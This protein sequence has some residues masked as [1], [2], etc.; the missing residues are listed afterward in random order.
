MSKEIKPNRS[1]IIRVIISNYDNKGIK[2]VKVRYN[3]QAQLDTFIIESQIEEGAFILKNIKW[4]AKEKYRYEMLIKELNNTSVEIIKKDKF[5]NNEIVRGYRL[6]FKIS[7][8]NKDIVVVEI[9]DLLSLK[10]VQQ[11]ER[12]NVRRITSQT[13]RKLLNIETQISYSKIAS[14]F[15]EDIDS[16]KIYKIKRYLNYRSNMLLF[17]SLINDFLCE[18]LYDEKGNKINELW[19]ITNKV[20]KDIIDERVNKIAKNLDNT[21]SIEL[22]NYNNR[23]KKSI[24]KKKNSITD[25]KN[26]IVSC[27]RKIEKLDE[28]K[29]RKKISQFKRDIANCN[30]KIKEYEESIVLKEKEKLFNLGFEKIKDDVYK[31]LE[32]YTELRHKLSHYNYIYFENLFENREEDLKLA[33]LLNLNIFNYLTLSKKLR[34]ENKTNYL[35]EDTKF[36]I[37]GVSGSAKKYYSLYN[38]LCEQKNGFNNFINSFFVKDGVENSEFK[39]KVEAKLKEDIEYLESFEIKNNLNKRIPKKNKELELLKSQYNELGTVYFWD[40]HSS[41]NYKELYNKR[42]GTIENYNQILKGNRNKTTLRNYGRELF[43]KK[44]E[45]EKITKRNSIVRLKYKLQI[46]YAFIMKEFKGDISRFKSDFDISKIEQ[47]K[48]YQSRGEEY[49]NYCD[50]NNFKIKDFQKMIGEIESSSEITWLSNKVENNLF[51]FYVLTYIL[52]PIEFKGDF[53]G[54][55]KKHY[56]DI[57][58]V[59]Y[60]DENL[61]ELT[62]EELDKIKNDSF[63]NKIRLFEKNSKKYNIFS[64]SILIQERVKDYFK[65]LDIPAEHYEYTGSSGETKNIF[66]K[67]IVIPIFKYYEIVVKLYNDIEIAMLLYLS[68]IKNISIEKVINR[69]IEKQSNLK[70]EHKEFYTLTEL[71]GFFKLVNEKAEEFDSNIPIPKNYLNSK[72]IS[73]RNNIFHYNYEGFIGQLLDINS[74]G[75]S[76]FSVNIEIRKLLKFIDPYLKKL[77]ILHLDYNFINDYYMKK[78]Q[79]MFGQLK[80]VD[81]TITNNEEKERVIK[82]KRLLEICKLKLEKDNIEVINKIYEKSVL[83]KEIGETLKIETFNELNSLKENRVNLNKIKYIEDLCKKQKKNEQKIN[84]NKVKEEIIKCSSDVLGLYKQQIITLLKNKIIRKLKYKEEK[85]L[86]IITYEVET[87]AK[88]IYTILIERKNSSNNFYFLNDSRNKQ[89]SINGEKIIEKN[90]TI[91]GGHSQQRLNI[92]DKTT[93]ILEIGREDEEKNRIDSFNLYFSLNKKKVEEKIFKKESL[94][95]R[96]HYSFLAEVKFKDLNK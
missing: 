3:K 54:F 60:L 34:I 86:T 57:K 63:F 92:G 21:L 90:I 27:E 38:T 2:E 41:L 30:E 53:L 73:L 91:K 15:P 43:S 58:N 44:N 19:R 72:P 28:E 13:E 74:E 84:V 56:Y 82:N 52:L 48:E 10:P 77:K 4:K 42:K 8:K 6:N 85:L 64:K 32:I 49:L 79:F 93:L 81:F 55:V 33:E 40:I 88:N 70:E 66:N 47:I 7:P 35:E 95:L 68:N 46:A 31:V 1:S 62:N 24:E 20:D 61:N 87:K 65:R 12:V 36:S 51:K 59:E 50:Q 25:C 18:G 67:N 83:L 94:D 22:K 14:C 11:G 16:I 29:D 80:Q 75:A 26:K 37:L 45:M 9:E 69:I 78:E 17:F 89:Q 23:I 76:S 5:L 71:F 96:E 39:E